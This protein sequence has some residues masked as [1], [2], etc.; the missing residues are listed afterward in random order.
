MLI[1][2][3]GKVGWLSGVPARDLSDEEVARYGR[4]RLLASGLYAEPDVDAGSVD[5]EAVEDVQ[6]FFDVRTDEEE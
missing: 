3:G 4:E 2:V 5:E 1:Y 6:E